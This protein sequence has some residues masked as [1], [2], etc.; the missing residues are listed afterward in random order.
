MTAP[1]DLREPGERR[2][3]RLER[4]PELLRERI[5]IIDGAMGTMIQRHQLDEAAFRGERFRDHPRDLRGVERPAGDHAA[6][7]HPRHP[8]RVPGRR[9]RHHRDQHVQRQPRLAGRLR[10]R[11]RWPRRSTRR[12]RAWRGR[13][14]TPP[15]HATPGGR[16]TWPGPSG[17][18]P[19]P[20]R[21]P[22]T[23]K[24]PAPAASRS[25]SSPWR[26]TRRPAAWWPAARTCCSSRR[27]STRST[28]RPRS[29][30]WSGSSTSSATGCR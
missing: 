29:S 1:T 10:S 27:S 25:T 7:R 4:L 15:R 26:I 13:P 5:L 12:R 9:R 19:G 30:G 2:G 24:T 6:R 17:R 11:G 18:R 23:S 20:R 16:A 3:R 22:R 21:S 28:A 8:R 14:R